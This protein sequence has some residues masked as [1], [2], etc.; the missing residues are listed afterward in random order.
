MNKFNSIKN[1]I[2]FS[3]LV[4]FPI[5]MQAQETSEASVEQSI[6][7]I[8]AG[9]LGVWGYN[10]S[11]LT[12]T[13][14]LRSEIGFEITNVYLFNITQ[15]NELFIPLVL[16][17]EPRYYFDLK[18]LNSKGLS[19]ENNAASFFSL[20]IRYHA[21][22]LMLSGKQPSNL[23][24][25]PTFASRTN[26]GKN[27]NFEIGGGMGYQYIFTSNLKEEE[28]DFWAFNL[29]LRIGYLF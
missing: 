3:V 9:R 5:A 12:N 6:F 20:K 16:V 26:I 29:V 8:Q 24:I 1:R 14:A 27:F 10:E 25:I 28:K 18:K 19:I 21:G 17:I 4:L 23:Q 2:L 7:G 13:I 22:W 11:K 15:G